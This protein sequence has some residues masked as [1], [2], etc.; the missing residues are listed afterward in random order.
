M[1]FLFARMDDYQMIPLKWLFDIGFLMFLNHGSF[2]VS[3][4]VLCL[5]GIV[6]HFGALCGCLH[7]LI[8]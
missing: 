3:N 6:T 7:H 5:E 4:H 2:I 8:Y 1:P